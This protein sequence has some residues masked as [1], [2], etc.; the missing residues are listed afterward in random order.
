MGEY[1]QVGDPAMTPTEGIKQVATDLK[2]VQEVI[3]AAKKVIGRKGGGAAEDNVVAMEKL[4][5][6][7]NMTMELGG[8]VKRVTGELKKEAKDKATAEKKLDKALKENEK[9]TKTAE[10]AESE[11]D[12]QKTQIQMVGFPQFTRDIYAGHMGSGAS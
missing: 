5:E 3:R 7:L 12:D 8:T 6:A 4:E 1:K 9:L 2:S 11:N 10:A